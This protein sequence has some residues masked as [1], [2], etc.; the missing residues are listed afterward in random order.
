MKRI[1]SLFLV[2]LLLSTFISTTAFADLAEY[3]FVVNNV[4][5][6]EYSCPAPILEYKETDDGGY[7]ICKYR[8]DAVNRFLTAP[9][10]QENSAAPKKWHT[11]LTIDFKFDNGS[12]VSE[13]GYLDNASSDIFTTEH[14]YQTPIKEPITFVLADF[15]Q[16]NPLND[17]D[18]VYT[19]ILEEDN[20]TYTINWNKH[21]IEVRI[22]TTIT[23]GYDS[24]PLPYSPSAT[25]GDIIND[26]SNPP[27]AITLPTPNLTN[28]VVNSDNHFIS[29]Q[30]FEDSD[31]NALIASNHD[32]TTLVKYSINDS[33]TSDTQTINLTENIYTAVAMPNNVTTGDTIVVE[34]AYFDA[35]TNTTSNWAKYTTT[36][37]SETQSEIHPEFIMPPLQGED[38]ELVIEMQSEH[39]CGLCGCCAYQPLSICLWMWGCMGVSAILIVACIISI[40]IDVRKKK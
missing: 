11:Q 22:L 10:T 30:L 37:Q 21:K 39:K 34:V 1:I 23:F 36:V 40:I 9:T 7:I 6:D 31:V 8:P 5:I 3:I 19:H 33:F 26:P 27:S 12:W 15:R 24:F 29:Y 32:I 35:T 28:L 2:I 25:L 20:G 18:N 17:P 13:L 16:Y 14:V 4:A 38:A